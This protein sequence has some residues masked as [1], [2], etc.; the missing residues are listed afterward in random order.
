MLLRFCVEGYRGFSERLVF[1][2]SKT[3]DY[4]F[5]TDAIRD[6]VVKVALV[7]GRNG[8]GKTNLG[9][10]L[11]DVRSN[12]AREAPA[13]GGGA[14]Y[15]NADSERATASFS[16][17]F[18]IDGHD[19]LYEY[20]KDARSVVRSERLCV[21]GVTVYD[22][23]ETGIWKVNDLGRYTSG[24]LV[25]GSRSLYLG[26][27]V[28]SYACTNTPH[29]MLGPLLSL[30]RFILSMQQGGGATLE[31]DVA[32]VIDA[33]RVDNLESFLR[34]H[35]IDES[36]LAIQDAA[37]TPVLYMRRGV[38]AIPFI[39]ACSSGTKALVRLF[40]I[41]E[42]DGSAP[43]LLFLD[44]FD[45]H[46]HHDL[47]EAVLHSLI[48]DTDVQ[49][50]ATTHNTDLFSNRTLRPDCLFVLSTQGISSA[51]DATTRELRE[52]HNL[53]RLYKAGEFDV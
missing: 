26:L 20:T 3:R 23:D 27:S 34:A 10:A 22:V 42:L 5:N 29:D 7:Y 53:E 39:E 45:A 30:Y 47:A 31:Q 48:A 19:M 25:T 32:A 11:L 49:V 12:V 37:G 33:N 52:G 4:R 15:L 13:Y 9:T 1:D 44:E 17:L 38:R 43:S 8:V 28:L 40:V 24:S 36:L 50:V 2:L 41:R 35:G 18:R 6:G 16:Y 51:S 14:T 46:Y 21:D